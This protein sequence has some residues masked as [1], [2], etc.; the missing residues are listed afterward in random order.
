MHSFP[1]HFL[2]AAATA[3]QHVEGQNFNSDWSAWE[4]LPG[5][6]RNGDNSRVACDWWGGGRWREDFD[7]AASLGMNAQRIGI[8]WARL[9]PEQGKWDAAAVMRYR[10]MISGLRERGMEPFV[11]L[12]HF[13]SPQWVAGRGGFENPEISQWMAR[14]AE[15]AAR[16]FGD[17]VTFWITLNEPN[18]YAVECYLRGHW[19]AQKK[20]FLAMLRV[21]KNTVRAHAAMYHAV[22][23]VK[24]DAQVGY[25]HHWRVFEPCNPKSPLDRFMAGL[26]TRVL[27]DVV[28][29]AIVHGVFEPPLALNESIPEARGT[30]D[31]IG[32]NYYYQEYT[33]FDVSNPVD[34]YARGVFD[35]DHKRF[36]E[37]FPEVGN[38]YPQALFATLVHLGKYHL[39]IYITENGFFQTDRDDQT[40]YLVTH[41]DAVYQAI[42]KGID[43][44]GYFWWSLLDNFEWA[45]GY[46]PR[47]GLYHTDFET[48]TRTLR[49][50]G[51]V[52][53][54]IVRDNGIS[55]TLLQEY[56]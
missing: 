41:L 33:K 26:R 17:L 47:F 20:D 1:P 13:A 48:Q 42:Q 44:R 22:K 30:Q 12:H 6:I 27:D 9:E 40:R 18:T 4:Q 21:L 54:Q 32:V 5:K 8:E 38:L 2:W 34:V 37:Y 24:P 7:R 28:F 49:K 35:E 50:V 43:V 15:R 16:E 36:V 53:G 45:Q 46:T 31:F 11:T 19:L 51:E 23:K 56:K 52:Y 25:S 29:D 55:D 39:P 10:E 3:G 14:Y